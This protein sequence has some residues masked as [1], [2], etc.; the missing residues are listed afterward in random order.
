MGSVSSDR[1][2]ELEQHLVRRDPFGVLR[3]AVLT[4]DLAELARPVGQ[5][6]RASLVDQARVVCP[7]GVV[8]TDAREP[9]L[10]ELV[11]AARIH[12]EG[13]YVA[14]RFAAAAPDQLGAAED[15]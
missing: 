15:P 14:G 10:S 2:Q 13:G 8:V 6:E 7:I 4:T 5:D 12:A 11:F 9:S 1:E 3:V